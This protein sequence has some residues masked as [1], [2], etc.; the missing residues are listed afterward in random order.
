MFAR[1][2]PDLF[3]RC[4]PYE[5][6]NMWATFGSYAVIQCRP[7]ACSAISLPEVAHIRM[8]SGACLP[9]WTYHS[10]QLKDCGRRLCRASH[11]WKSISVSKQLR[12]DGEMYSAKNECLSC[13]ESAWDKFHK[14]DKKLS[15]SLCLAPHHTSLNRSAIIS[16]CPEHHNQDRDTTLYF[17]ITVH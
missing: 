13:E 17:Y 10:V 9:L 12:S 6:F 2:G 3:M 4:G 14:G 16:K 1:R 7:W 15:G 5:H 11:I 8:L